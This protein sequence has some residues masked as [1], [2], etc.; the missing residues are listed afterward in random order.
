MDDRGFNIKLDMRVCTLIFL[1]YF[2]M[3]YMLF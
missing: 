3:I 1:S 2:A